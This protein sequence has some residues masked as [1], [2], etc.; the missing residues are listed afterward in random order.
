[1]AS[2]S[3]LL[4]ILRPS[5]PSLPADPRALLKTKTKYNIKYINGGQYYHFGVLKG[6]L[7]KL[8]CIECVSTFNP[9]IL[10]QV[11]I[12]GLPLFKSSNVQFWPI[13][14]RIESEDIKMSES[15]VFFVVKKTQKKL[16]SFYMILLK[17]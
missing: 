2:L 12:D 16:Q 6:A 5:H 13:L 9:H 15:L 14:G 10:V 3:A 7:Q 4:A 11:N 17:R 1:M 8:A